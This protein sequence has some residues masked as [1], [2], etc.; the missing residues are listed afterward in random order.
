MI[1]SLSEDEARVLY[2]IRIQLEPYV[3]AVS[4]ETTARV[5]PLC[6]ARINCRTFAW[7]TCLRGVAHIL[8]AMVAGDRMTAGE[9][10]DE[11]PRR[12]PDLALKVFGMAE[13]PA[14]REW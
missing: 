9:T 2:D 12:A 7:P 8:K 6:A 14:Q 11:H 3:V 10:S 4:P 5:E 13:R 1:T